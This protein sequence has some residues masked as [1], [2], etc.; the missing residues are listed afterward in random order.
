MQESGM[1]SVMCPTGV[2]NI[3]GV[4]WSGARADKNAVCK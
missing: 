2:E 4:S 3:Y 1:G